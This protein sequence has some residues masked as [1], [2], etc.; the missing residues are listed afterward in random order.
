[1]EIVEKNAVEIFADIGSGATQGHVDDCPEDGKKLIH[2]QPQVCTSRFFVIICCPQVL[3]RCILAASENSEQR[4]N[5]R[6]DR[7]DHLREVVAGDLGKK[8][9]QKLRDNRHLE[10]MAPAKPNKKWVCVLG[11]AKGGAAYG[12][13]SKPFVMDT[14]TTCFQA[15]KTE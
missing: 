8:G 6:G 2:G 7:V 4:E 15:S 11:Q 12:M 14:M 3:F 13:L 9:L 10:V 5:H 1:M